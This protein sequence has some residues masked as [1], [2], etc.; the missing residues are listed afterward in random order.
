MSSIFRRHCVT[1]SA[2]VRT[3]YIFK[4]V[5]AKEEAMSAALLAIFSEYKVAERVRVELV[6]DGFPT[7]RV[8]LTAGCETGRLTH[9]LPAL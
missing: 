1:K 8:E 7:D 5:T 3:P 9:E 4:A 2:P 6:R